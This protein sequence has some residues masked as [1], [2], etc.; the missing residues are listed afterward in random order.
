GVGSV[1]DQPRRAT[2]HAGG[3]PAANRRHLSPPGRRPRRHASQCPAAHGDHSHGRVVRCSLR[4]RL[5]AAHVPCSGWVEQV[6]AESAH[7]L[8]DGGLV[9]VPRFRDWTALIVHGGIVAAVLGLAA[10]SVII[11][12][13]PLIGFLLPLIL[14][15]IYGWL[16]YAFFHY[17]QGRQEEFLYLL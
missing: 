8:G 16:L 2:R 5:D 7:V 9:S 10:T 15:L 3:N 4:V 11:L 17:R 12:R 1:D 6:T 14:F 13:A